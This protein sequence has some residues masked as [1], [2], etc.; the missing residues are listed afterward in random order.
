MFKNLTVP[1]QVQSRRLFF[2]YQCL[3]PHILLKIWSKLRFSNSDDLPFLWEHINIFLEAFQMYFRAEF[4]MTIQL[5]GEIFLNHCSRKAALHGLHPALFHSSD[6]TVFQSAGVTLLQ[7]DKN[8]R[9]MWCTYCIWGMEM[10]SSAKYLHVH[11]M[12]P[13]LRLELLNLLLN[14]CICDVCGL[15]FKWCSNL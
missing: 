10:C 14:P 8:E 6:H 2:V 15:L 11:Y 4:K 1:L 9:I 5:V 3:L 7:T 12:P 13:A